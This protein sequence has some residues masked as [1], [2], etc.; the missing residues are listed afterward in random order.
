MLQ[1]PEILY[2]TPLS[3]LIEITKEFLKFGLELEIF[4]KM[5]PFFIIFSPSPQVK[6]CNIFLN[7]SGSGPNF[8]NHFRYFT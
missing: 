5:L 2:G 1:D 4:K 7:I 8:K 3:V 6:N